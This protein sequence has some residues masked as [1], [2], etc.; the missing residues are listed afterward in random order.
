MKKYKNPFKTLT[1]VELI[2]WITSLVTIAVSYSAIPDR[3]I[4]TLIASLVGVTALI[5]VAKGDPMGQ[6]L[7]VVFSVIYGIISFRFRYYGEMITYLCMS[8]PIAIVST[9]AWFRNPHSD[10]ENQVRVASLGAKRV[11]VLFAI[12]LLVSVAF[13]FILEY[14]NTEN[15][16]FSTLSVLTSFFAASLTFF[17]SPYYGLAYGANDVVLIVLWVLAS[18]KDISYL[19][20]VFC[21]IVFL[22]NDSYGFYNWGRLRKRQAADLLLKNGGGE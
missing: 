14:F 15:L 4:M 10:E 19:P 3:D 11:S 20:M 21:F 16:I 6:I 9:V 1:R 18:V 7:T 2:L 5:F 8:M 12:S 22:A 17:R 13:Y